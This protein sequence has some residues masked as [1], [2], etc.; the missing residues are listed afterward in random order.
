[1]RCAPDTSIREVVELMAARHL[2]SMVVVDAEQQPLG[3]FTLSD[4]LK[5][6]VLPGTSLEQPIATVMSPAPADLAAGCQRARCGAR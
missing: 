6:I 5:R 4:V 1:L 2:G 3:I